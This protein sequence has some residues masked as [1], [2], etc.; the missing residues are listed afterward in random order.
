MK[1]GG[2]VVVRQGVQLLQGEEFSLEG[3][4]TYGDGSCE[5]GTVPGAARAGWGF[6]AVKEGEVV[7]EVSGPVWEGLP[8]TSQAGEHAGY[9]A[10]VQT[11]EAGTKAGLDCETVVLEANMPLKQRLSPKRMYGGLDRSLLPC[12]GLP[13][14]SVFKVEGHAS[15]G[16]APTAE[17]KAHAIGN[18]AADGQAKDGRDRHP[19]PKELLQEQGALFCKATAICRM[20]AEVLLLWPSLRGEGLLKKR[21]TSPAV[22]VDPGTLSAPAAPAGP[23]YRTHV[24]SLHFSSWRCLCGA[25]TTFA[26]TTTR[27]RER[28]EY[29]RTPPGRGHTLYCMRF[30]DASM[31]VCWRCGSHG[32]T[33]AR[34]LVAPC[35]PGPTLAGRNVLKRVREGK[36]PRGCVR[37][38]ADAVVPF[39]FGE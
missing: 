30:G 4:I 2:V 28:C 15:I 32:A 12:R 3:G 34:G 27:A 31:I 10:I 11:A 39:I 33:V 7:L 9:A 20:G 13:L 16:N 23:A 8:Q 18:D 14:T 19:L 36:H 25:K 21:A 1:D 37:E 17:L 24:W 35:P 26:G 6:V 38:V 5:K 29:I 22:V